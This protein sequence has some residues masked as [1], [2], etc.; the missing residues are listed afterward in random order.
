[1]TRTAEHVIF[2]TGAI[3]LATLTNPTV[4]E[5][6]EMRYLF[7]APYIVDSSK[8]AARLGVKATPLD[9]ALTETLNTYRT[10]TLKAA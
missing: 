5:L 10:A 1:M 9:Q 6:I 7:Q 3:G 4:R 8:I 2:G